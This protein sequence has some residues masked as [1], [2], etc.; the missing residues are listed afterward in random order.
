MTYINHILKLFFEAYK[1]VFHN[2]FSNIKHDKRYKNL[3]EEEKEKKRKKRPEKDIKIFLRK[4]KKKNRN[5]NL[6]EKKITIKNNYQ[7]IL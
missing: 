1:N 5:K 7:D 4:K 3:S 2:I 6:F